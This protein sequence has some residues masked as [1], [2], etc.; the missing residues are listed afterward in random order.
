M[1]SPKTITNLFGV[2]FVLASIPGFV[3]NLIVFD[4][5]LFAGNN[6]HNILHIVTG[7]AFLAAGYLG[8]ARQ[9]I[10]SVGLG[11]LAVTAIGFLITGNTLLGVVDISTSHCWQHAG[12]AVVILLAGYLASDE[13]SPSSSRAA[14]R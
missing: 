4:D 2:T 1:L 7:G 14:A 11:H 6:V 8:Y 13:P 10:L 12:L 3:L 5:G 9:T